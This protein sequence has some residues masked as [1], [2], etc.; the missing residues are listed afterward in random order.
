MTDPE[1]V[2]FFLEFLFRFNRWSS[3]EGFLLFVIVLLA[4]L[5]T[6]AWLLRKLLEEGAQVYTSIRGLGL[7][8][9]HSAATT[10]MIRR[11]KA[12][13]TA[14]RGDIATLAKAENWND[15]YFTDLEAEVEVEGRY[16][17]SQVHR[18]LGKKSIGLR[19]ASSLVSALS[20]SAEQF[21]VVLGE[22]GSGKSIALRHLAYIL[23]DSAISSNRADAPIP[24]YV[25]LRELPPPQTVPTADY[26]KS[27]VIEN[28]RRGDADTA[29]Y[30][31]ENWESFRDAGRWL[32]LLDS[33]D[34]IPEIIH[35]P[36]GSPIIG[37]YTSAVRQFLEAMTPCKAL[38]ASREYKGP[39]A[40]PW[41][42]LRILPLSEK[43]QAEL[44]E[45]S[46]LND[47]QR[48]CV[49]HHVNLKGSTLYQNPLFLTLLCRHVKTYLV[50]PLNDHDLI[51]RHLEYLVGRDVDYLAQKYELKPDKL[52][53][54][55]TALA[56]TFA[57]SDKLSLSPTQS[58]IGTALS[59]KLGDHTQL[60]R[61]LAALIDVKLFRCDVPSARQGDRRLAFAHRR[62]QESLFVKHLIRNPAHI[63]DSDKLLDARW[64]DYTVAL[65][66]IAPE[67]SLH[68]LLAEAEHILKKSLQDDVT[69]RVIGSLRAHFAYYDWDESRAIHVLRILQD[70][71]IDR[72]QILPLTLRQTIGRLLSPRWKYGDVEDRRNVIRYGALSP[73]RS[74][75]LRIASAI[76]FGFPAYSAVAFQ[77][78]ANLSRVPGVIGVWIRRRIAYSLF[79]ARQRS[80][81]IQLEAIASR[82]PEGIGAMESF[83]LANRY[84]VIFG[85]IYR[86]SAMIQRHL[87]PILKISSL[88]RREILIPSLVTL[89]LL[90]LTVLSGYA[91]AF[92]LKASAAII[93]LVTSRLLYVHEKLL[94]GKVR[95][96]RPR[97]SVRSRNII[98]LV[99]II[100][101]AIAFVMLPGALTH[102]VLHW[103]KKS[104]SFDTYG[105]A[106]IVMLSLIALASMIREFRQ[107]RRYQR[108]AASAGQLSDI[109]PLSNT[110]E[111]TVWVKT[112]CAELL[113]TLAHLRSLICIYS[114]RSRHSDPIERG[115]HL[116]LLDCLLAELDSYRGRSVP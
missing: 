74:Q 42:K 55:A 46:F 44:I 5:C 34:E 116:D 26:I 67:E 60:Q 18:I 114:H 89:S 73:E 52:L 91:A 32:I 31:K 6:I 97:M 39:L 53:D 108:S 92:K 105:T 50:P 54:A 82:L 8:L 104:V 61:I 19:K 63:S 77:R 81:R 9:I 4:S 10:A 48:A 28:V 106:A 69:I 36:T 110:P 29:E 86:L 75:I 64:R 21:Q 16:F 94:R 7:P 103:R 65:L 14:I 17:E 45:N 111:L 109:V 66:Q 62:Y 102:A 95:F 59:G 115:D 93:A 43:K 12:F 88:Y 100:L 1:L 41:P 30:I 84:V 25:N 101:F 47:E 20:A 72:K 37:A 96:S 56:V 85:P 107:S 83:R 79:L 57:E 33:F 87:A 35:A 22:P 99:S 15:Q 80:T 23:A 71:L 68:S 76:K 113:P 112:R 51:L 98:G 11:R 38:I 3:P 90:E 40:L 70:G 24:L 13:C 2:K 49:E 78:I 27:H 58:E